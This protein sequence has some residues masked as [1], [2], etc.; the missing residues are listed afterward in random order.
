MIPTGRLHDG[1]SLVL[2]RRFTAPIDDVWASITESERLSRWFGT[3][4]GDP[5]TGSVMVTM[6]AEADPVP[7]VPYDIVACDPPRQL[8]IR[9]TDDYGTWHLTASLTEDGSGTTLVLRQD[10]VDPGTVPETGPGWEWYLDR[11]VAAVDG[12]PPPTLDDFETVYLP[13][14]AAYAAMRD[15]P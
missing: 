12:D 9:A 2:E 6:T 1:T 15:A 3:W 11:L 13:M 8:S 7:P 4:T 14:S 10:E 5:T